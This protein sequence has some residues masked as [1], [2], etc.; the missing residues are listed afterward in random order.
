M[1]CRGIASGTLVLIIVVGVLLVGGM[2]LMGSYNGLVTKD[3]VVEQK[4]ADIE[5][6]LKRRADLVP[7]LVATV[8]GYASHEKEIFENIANARSRL[9]TVKISDDPAAAQAASQQF[10]SALSRL[11]AIAENYPDLKAD[12]SFI[13]LQDEL[14]GTE[15]RINYARLEFNKA[16][17]DYNRTVRSFPTNLLAGIAGFDRKQPFEA[18]EA[19]KALPTVSF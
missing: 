11:L 14:A 12:Q 3:T 19:D 7:N 4:A 1:K 9:L 13:R 17:Q 8:K 16:I 15:N 6:Q 5:S 18:D 2:S 10:N